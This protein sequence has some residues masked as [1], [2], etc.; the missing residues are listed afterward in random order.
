MRSNS[1]KVSQ[2]LRGIGYKTGNWAIMLQRNTA[3]KNST[4]FLYG[5]LEIFL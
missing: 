2:T 4:R 1:I 3:N 5:T